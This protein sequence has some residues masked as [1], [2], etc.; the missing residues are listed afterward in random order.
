[1]REHGQEIQTMPEKYDM[2]QIKYFQKPFLHTRRRTVRG[3]NTKAMCVLLLCNDTWKQFVI[4]VSDTC[5][6]ATL[7]FIAVCETRISNKRKTHT[8]VCKLLFAPELSLCVVAGV[9][10]ACSCLSCHY[11][12]GCWQ[13]DD[14]SLLRFLHTGMTFR[15]QRFAVCC[16]SC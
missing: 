11:F 8:T 14:A 2:V 1:M 9:L 13:A 15:V 5:L 12:L 16:C 7:A 3:G 10:M 4:T 6:S